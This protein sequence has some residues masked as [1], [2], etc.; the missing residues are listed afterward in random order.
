M[1]M[2]MV[3]DGDVAEREDERECNVKEASSYAPGRLG[4][5]KEETLQLFLHDH[6]DLDLDLDGFAVD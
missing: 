5:E 6:L 2:P 3:D 4:F 1:M